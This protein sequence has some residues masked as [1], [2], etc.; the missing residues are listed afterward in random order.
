MSIGIVVLPFPPHQIGIRAKSLGKGGCER[1]CGCN[2]LREEVEK[3]LKRLGKRKRSQV[4]HNGASRCSF[5]SGVV[6]FKKVLAK[7]AFTTDEDR[8]KNKRENKEKRQERYKSR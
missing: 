8:E 6:T 2:R 3:K 7:Q 5:N 1:L 4:R